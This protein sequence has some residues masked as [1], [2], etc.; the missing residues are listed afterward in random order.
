MSERSG[1]RSRR[2]W[3]RRWWIVGAVI[4]AMVVI[5]LVVTPHD[6]A[7]VPLVVAGTIAVGVGFGVE[8]WISS[9]SDR[10]D[11]FIPFTRRGLAAAGPLIVGGLAVLVVGATTF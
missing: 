2:I 6:E 7:N 1:P 8:R 9:Q 5:R 4:A 10:G 11:P 3:A